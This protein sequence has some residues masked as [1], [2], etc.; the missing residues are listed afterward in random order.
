MQTVNSRIQRQYN[1]DVLMIDMRSASAPTM[2]QVI[3]SPNFDPL[4]DFP[5]HT[6]QVT[7][8][9][10]DGLK[11]NEPGDRRSSHC[12]FVMM[13]RTDRFNPVGGSDARFLKQG[14]VVRVIEGDDSIP[15]G[16]WV[17][18]FTGILRGQTGFMTDRH[19][20]LRTTQVSAYGR[21]GTALYNKM[22][23]ISETF[24]RN[25]DYATITNNIATTIMGLGGGELFRFPNA[26]GKTTQFAANSI[27][28]MTALEAIDKILEAVGQVSDFDGAGI[29]RTY[30]RDITRDEDKRYDNLD[31]IFKIT[32][33]HAEV[34]GFNSVT[35]IGLDKNITETEHPDQN[36]AR[37]EITAGFWRP[38]HE[39]KVQWSD[40][41]STRAKDTVMEIITS[42]KQTLILTFGEEFYDEL[43]AFGGV[44]FV[45]LS[46]F[47]GTLIM[48]IAVLLITQSLIPDTVLSIGAGGT[49]S[50]GR[51][52]QAITDSLVK[53]VFATISTGQYEIKGTVLIPV[54][55]EISVVL[56]ETGVPDYLLNQKEIRNDL[57]NEQ[58]ELLTI[59]ELEL[60]FEHAQAEP[61]A[62]DV[63]NDLE[64]E[65]G[66][67]VHLP[68]GGGLRIWIDAL[69]K[70]I[71]RGAVPTINV[72][73]Y[74]AL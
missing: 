41:R 18:T 36:L 48:V 28:D 57:L 21:R 45:D 9:V 19:N 13:D 51:A 15:T 71:S 64:L 24:G 10:L 42:V 44:I 72:Q 65:I 22:P 70:S 39:V 34:D 59:A 26:V 35:V 25:I 33:P 8:F 46:A 56:T 40:D 54:F 16:D 67:I 12:Q 17:T 68:Q 7:Q 37:A 49:L 52:L 32:I 11:I 38:R 63:L 20:V 73:G 62:Y 29:L 2:R 74:R 14:T 3:E 31:L 53:K 55:K 66:D 4:T 27:V 5:D 61:R 1:Y 30:S 58:T 69:S 60:I 47:F 6:F 43:D 50:V 23:F